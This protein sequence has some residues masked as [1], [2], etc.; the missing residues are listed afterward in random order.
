MNLKDNTTCKK[1]DIKFNSKENL[2][3][4]INIQYPKIECE[5]TF[6]KNYKLENHMK[7]HT[8]NKSFWCGK[9]YMKFKLSSSKNSIITITIRFVHL[10]K[11]AVNLHMMSP[12]NVFSKKIAQKTCVSLD[13]IVRR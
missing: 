13:T 4:H 8:G 5:E 7:S 2:Q 9:C 6:G 11:M 10:L 3:T 12:W 1:C